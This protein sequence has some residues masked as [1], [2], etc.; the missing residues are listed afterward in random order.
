MLKCPVLIKVAG[1]RSANLL[2]LGFFPSSHWNRKF[3]SS[4]PEAFCKKSVL[5]N[6]AKFIG[7]HLFQRI[8]FNKALACNFIKK[9]SRAEV[10]SCEFCAIS[11]NIL[12]TEHLRWLF[13]KIE[14]LHLYFSKFLITQLAG[15]SVE[16]LFWRISIFAEHLRQWLLL[17]TH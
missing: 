16:Q 10:F 6:F 15:Y 12:F 1:Y 4:R 7:K 11:K 9:E 13:L 17:F 5:K 3:R 2:K 14:P 8:F